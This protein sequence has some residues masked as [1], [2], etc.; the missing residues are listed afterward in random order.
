MEILDN[1]TRGKVGEK[2]KVQ[3]Y[4]MKRLKNLR[5]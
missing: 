5:I 1:K 2:L 3:S 4:N